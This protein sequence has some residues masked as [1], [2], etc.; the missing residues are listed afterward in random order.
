MLRVHVAEKKFKCATCGKGFKDNGSL[1]RHQLVHSEERPFKC[2]Q[3]DK[4]FKM[5]QELDGHVR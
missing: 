1:I 3:C 5:K 2:Q 4:S